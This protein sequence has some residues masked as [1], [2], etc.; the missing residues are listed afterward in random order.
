MGQHLWVSPAPYRSEAFHQANRHRPASALENIGER[1]GQG[2]LDTGPK[3]PLQSYHY[4]SAFAH[5][6]RPCW[7]VP[8]VRA[9][10]LGAS[11]EGPV[12]GSSR[13]MGGRLSQP[14]RQ[15]TG[16]LPVPVRTHGAPRELLQRRHASALVPPVTSHNSRTPV[17][18]T[19]VACGR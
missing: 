7:P 3:R 16:S 9:A 13:G 4:R 15:D 8:N 17:V 19:A 11:R 5:C 2:S 14:G 12:S 1:S 6:H 18:G 10:P